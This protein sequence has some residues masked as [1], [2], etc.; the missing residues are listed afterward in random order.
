M[1]KIKVRTATVLS[2]SR[3]V[4]ISFR[5]NCIFGSFQ[6]GTFGAAAQELLHNRMIR[7]FELL[8]LSV[9][10]DF[11]SIKHRHAGPDA[12]GAVH[13]MRDDNRS[14]LRSLGQADD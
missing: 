14:Y 8:G 12:K 13:F 3:P 9:R 1:I 7:F 5:R 6:D 10:D 2:T 4:M 11:A